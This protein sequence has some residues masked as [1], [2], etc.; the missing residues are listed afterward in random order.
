MSWRASVRDYLQNHDALL[1]KARALQTK[2][3]AP[4]KPTEPPK[5][6]PVSRER[7][8]RELREAADWQLI[9]PATALSMVL[10]LTAFAEPWNQYVTSSSGCCSS[11]FSYCCRGRLF[12]AIVAITQHNPS[13]TPWDIGKILLAIVCVSAAVWAGNIGSAYLFSSARWKLSLNKRTQLFSQILAQDH[14]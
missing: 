9:L 2:G 14:A 8:L 11:L 3:K 1:A 6:L 13:V 7:L 10:Q 5:P 12:D 4:P